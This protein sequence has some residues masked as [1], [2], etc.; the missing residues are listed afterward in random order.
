MWL[1][2][3]VP[4]ALVALCAGRA[5]AD[6][7][8]DE[9]DARAVGNVVFTALATGEAG[10]LASVMRAPVDIEIELAPPS[11]CKPKY[12]PVMRVARAKLPAF[13]RCLAALKIDVRGGDVALIPHAPGYVVAASSE[14]VNVRLVLRKVKTEWKVIEIGVQDLGN[15]EGVEGGVV[16]GVIG[17]VIGAPPP[18]PPPPPPAPPQNVPPTALESLRI[19]G[20]KNIVPDADTIDAIRAAGKDRFTVPVKICVGRDGAM[21]SVKVMKSSGFPAYDQKLVRQINAW[22]YKPFMVNGAPTPVCSVVVFIFKL[23]P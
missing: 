3:V 22:K 23:T 8:A 21:Q 19:A 15:E 10:V 20:D 1:R 5:S 14:D 6:Q 17:G 12:K 18:P 16:G 4:L 7:Q 2:R 9:R 11:G 13:T